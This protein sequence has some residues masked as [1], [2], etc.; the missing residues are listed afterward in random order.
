MANVDA[1]GP[2]KVKARQQ[3]FAGMEPEKNAKLEDM[4]EAYVDARDARM[5][6]LKV[7]VELKQKLLDYMQGRNL[8]KYK[9][10]PYE[11]QVTRGKDEVKAKVKDDSARQKEE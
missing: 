6:A 2:G 9:R 11:A 7:E 3:H 5:E 1:K 4:I 8:K 10:G